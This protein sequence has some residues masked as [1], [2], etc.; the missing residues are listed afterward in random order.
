MP[1]PTIPLSLSVTPTGISPQTGPSPSNAFSTSDKESTNSF[2][3]QAG[4]DAVTGKNSNNLNVHR[5]P[6]DIGSDSIPHY[7]MFYINIRKNVAANTEQQ[8]NISSINFDQSSKNNLPTETNG[9]GAAAGASAGAALGQQLASSL[10]ISAFGSPFALVGAGTGVAFTTKKNGSFQ[11]IVQGNTTVLLK[12]V[13]A[14]YLNG[15]PSAQYSASWA[16]VDLGLANELGNRFGKVVG[17]VKDAWDDLSKK[18]WT[19]VLKDKGAKAIN[20]MFGGAGPATAALILRSADKSNG[21]FGNFGAALQADAAIVP[22]P[23]KAQL[24]HTMGFRVFT[25]DYTFLPKN[26]QEYAEVQKIIKIFKKYMHPVVG[27]EKFIMQYPAE[28]SIAYY[29]KGTTNNELFKMANCALTTCKVEYGGT[30]FTT[31]KRIPGGPTEISMQ[32]AF[33]ETELLTRDH[34]EAGY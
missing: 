10:A 27:G 2:V 16:D 31:F 28:F 21:A 4:A 30:D 9:L 20:D 7:V 1:G 13:V 25:F 6:H 26:A 3:F 14:L 23:F 29:Y 8:S 19:T 33:V 5:Y 24:F 18:D 22:N 11:S 34:I 17:D 15:K 32:L 12:D